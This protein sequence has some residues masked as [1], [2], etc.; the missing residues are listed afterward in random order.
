[1]SQNLIH[2]FDKEIENFVYNNSVYQYTIEHLCK[3]I[4]TC[5]HFCS[6]HSGYG[7]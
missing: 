4:G 7:V 5:F 1:M 6:K 2:V 3:P